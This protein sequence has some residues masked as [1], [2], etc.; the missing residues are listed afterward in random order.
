VVPGSVLVV[1]GPEPGEHPCSVRETHAEGERVLDNKDFRLEVVDA[2][3]KLYRE[4]VANMPKSPTG[5]HN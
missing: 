5:S 1:G 3:M 2:L 4:M